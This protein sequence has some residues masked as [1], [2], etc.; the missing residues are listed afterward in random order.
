M[1]EPIRTSGLALPPGPLQLGAST[2]N[3]RS[4]TSN[5]VRGPP[6]AETI[7]S[8]GSDLYFWRNVW[9]SDTLVMNGEPSRGRQLVLT[10]GRRGSSGSQVT[11]CSVH[12]NV[13]RN[14]SDP[15]SGSSM[16]ECASE[17]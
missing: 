13:L 11:P 7:T 17:Q 14:P 3:P 6:T 4:W 5:L 10:P 9:Y 8:R 1:S 12:R 2:G 15:L 16:A